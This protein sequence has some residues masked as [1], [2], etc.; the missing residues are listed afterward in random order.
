VGEYSS[1]A[2]FVKRID[3]MGRI[4]ARPNDRATMDAG[5]VFGEIVDAAA[6]KAGATSFAGQRRPRY[7]VTKRG[8]EVFIRPGNV[9][10]NV[11]LNSGAGAHI[12]GAQ[13]RGTK[14]KFRQ[15]AQR[16]QDLWSYGYTGAGR[17]GGIRQTK[18]GARSA[19]LKIGDE[20]ATYAN[21]PGMSGFGFVGASR[22]KAT[23]KGAEVYLA[24]IRR[25][26]GGAALR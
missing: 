6:D 8:R 26:L 19:A 10:A 23:T 21:H 3:E 1:V 16:A 18:T 7:R 4:V 2:D 25:E 22:D 14:A 20:F 17:F 13:G 24:A 12:I 11:V 9:G 15:H 5:T